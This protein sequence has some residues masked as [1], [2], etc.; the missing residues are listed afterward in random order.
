MESTL[1][2]FGL[3]KNYVVNLKSSQGAFYQKLKAHVH[4]KDLSFWIFFSER[5]I[6]T[7]KPYVG[8]FSYSKFQ[9][10]KRTK[11]MG[12]QQNHTIATGK[13]YEQSD[14]LRVEVSLG[15]LPS[16]VQFYLVSA[17]LGMLT[18]VLLAP[19]IF[20]SDEFNLFIVIFPLVFLFAVAANLLVYRNKLKSFEKEFNGFLQPT[21]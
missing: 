21:D 18:V 20:E 9:I 17:L 14:N 3:R 4:Q 2:N 19:R 13:Y 6:R 1:E 8:T 5:Y 10:K 7:E 11:F 16:F 12:S 15:I